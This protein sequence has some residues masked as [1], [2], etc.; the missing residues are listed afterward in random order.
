MCCVSCAKADLMLIKLFF[1][2][3]YC[4]LATAML[5]SE[6]YRCS[7]LK[8]QILCVELCFL[9]EAQATVPL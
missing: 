9:L 6:C 7:S 2:L 3:H 1:F 4:S 5:Q 8:L